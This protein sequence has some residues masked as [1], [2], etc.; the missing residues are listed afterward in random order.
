MAHDRLASSEV[1]HA[2]SR[3]DSCLAHIIRG[4]PPGHGWITTQQCGV[5]QTSKRLL[6]CSLLFQPFPIKATCGAREVLLQSGSVST[7][8]Q[9]SNR[10]N[11]GLTEGVDK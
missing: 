6:L 10:S 7:F 2:Y 11:T 9:R 4:L 5:F 1:K 3:G 8:S